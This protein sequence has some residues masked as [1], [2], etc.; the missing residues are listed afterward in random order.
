MILT[1]NKL[2]V[3]IPPGT[4][5]EVKRASGWRTVRGNS[6]PGHYKVQISYDHCHYFL[7]DGPKA[8]ACFIIPPRDVDMNFSP[9]GLRV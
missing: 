5:F 7:Y 8:G 4:A 6:P 1:Y 2:Q 9:E 3:H